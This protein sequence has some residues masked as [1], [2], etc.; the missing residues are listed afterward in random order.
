LEKAYLERELGPVDLDGLEII[1]MDEFALHKEHRYATVIVE[2][3]R[4]LVLWIGRGNGLKG[5]RPFFEQLGPDRCREIKAAVMDM[6]TGYRLEVQAHCPNAAIVFDLSHVVAKY[7]RE[8]IDR[9]RVDRANEL[10]S[11]RP[12]RRVVKVARWLLLKNRE[13]LRPG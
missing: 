6:N 13:S 11:D 4:K 9:F 1:G 12:S 10:R 7:G 2:P 5:I 8:V 3:T